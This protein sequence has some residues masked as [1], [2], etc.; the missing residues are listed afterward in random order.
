[1]Q[2]ASWRIRTCQTLLHNVVHT[3]SAAI[4]E[5]IVS[6]KNLSAFE[7]PLTCRMVASLESSCIFTQSIRFLWLGKF[8][9]V[10]GLAQLITR[11]RSSV[12]RMLEL[13]VCSKTCT[14]REAKRPYSVTTS[15]RD[16]RDQRYT[17]FTL[18]QPLHTRK[19][20][21]FHSF[22]SLSRPR[23]DS[24]HCSSVKIVKA[25][26][27]AAC[28]KPAKLRSIASADD[29]PQLLKISLVTCSKCHPYVMRIDYKTAS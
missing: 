22:P 2:N 10:Q 6:F 27:S 13:A 26:W 28:S 11:I 21:S 17:L 25:R 14:T 29:V 16:S 19:Q 23:Q 12:Q 4:Q 3:Q 7:I 1:M 24:G 9:S 15:S 18:I 5:Q 20:R 8:S